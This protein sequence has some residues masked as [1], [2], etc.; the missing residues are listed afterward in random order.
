MNTYNKLQKKYKVELSE[1]GKYADIYLITGVLKSHLEVKIQQ[2]KAVLSDS[3]K[4]TT[5]IIPTQERVTEVLPFTY[6]E[7]DD[8]LSVELLLENDDS[9]VFS[10]YVS[11]L[12]EMTTSN[13]HHH[14][15][16]H[17]DDKHYI[18][19]PIIDEYATKN[20]LRKEAERRKKD[21]DRILDILGVTSENT[22][23][24]SSQLNSLESALECE[25]ERSK[26]RDVDHCEAINKIH[27]ELHVSNKFLKD[28]LKDLRTSVN[29]SNK[30]NSDKYNE[31][32]STC[33]D[34]QHTFNDINSRIDKTNDEIRR[35]TKRASD[36]A[37]E[38]RGIIKQES[39]VRSKVDHELFDRI[40]Q[41]EVNSIEGDKKILR[42]IHEHVDSLQDEIDNID[43]KYQVKG[44]Y[45]EFSELEQDRKCIVLPNHSNILGEG[46]ENGVYNLVMVSKWN[47]ADFGSASLPLNLNGFNERPTYND[48]KS[49]AL[50][51]DVEDSKTQLEQSFTSA[52]NDLKESLT[53]TI[54]SKFDELTEQIVSLGNR[55]ND[56][57]TSVSNLDSQISELKSITEDS[58]KEISSLNDNV[59]SL[60]DS[61]T[62][63][64]DNYSVLSKTIEDNKTELT[65]AIDG[66]Q[67]SIDNNASDITS[68]QDELTKLQ[69]SGV[70][71]ISKE[72]VE[73]LNSIAQEFEGIKNMAT[74]TDEAVSGLTTQIEVVEKAIVIPDTVQFEVKDTKQLV[75]KFNEGEPILSALTKV[76]ES[77]VDSYDHIDGASF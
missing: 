54:N 43:D 31:L 22:S 41:V 73:T 55:I 75:L 24:I 13:F 59:V 10:L 72:T 68:I 8:M 49:L 64:T 9:Q 14:H 35:E 1:K 42:D 29:R 25:I 17:F 77:I 37:D 52:I 15:C 71:D 21:D 62:E 66:L 74:A 33:T 70:E 65:S 57:E 67:K 27:D 46:S 69:D 20:D 60:Q 6:D 50:V 3:I 45:V 12:M 61:V 39:D 26:H 63:L 51:S 16:N 7:E 40:R 2:G 11:D 30:E 56:C 32:Y 53:N 58:Q 38:I 18:H 36:E 76:A 48:N 44:D 23:S 47:V 19:K 28:E 34:I 4:H 5:S